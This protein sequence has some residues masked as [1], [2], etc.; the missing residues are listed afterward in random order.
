MI[1][2][3]PSKTPRDALRYFAIEKAQSIFTELNE[4]RGKPAIRS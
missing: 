1:I 2:I 3:E 4:V